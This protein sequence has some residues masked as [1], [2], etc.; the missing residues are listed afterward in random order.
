MTREELEAAG[1][2]LA[3]ASD[4]AADESTSARLRDL[5][6]QLGRLAERA[7]GPDHGR[8]ARH[9]YALQELLADAD[10]AVAERIEAA[11]DDIA[12]Y[13]ETVEGV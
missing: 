1:E 7:D 6:D 2:A 9:E 4:E 3:A 13:R 10:E 8:L 5:A 12:A 11:K